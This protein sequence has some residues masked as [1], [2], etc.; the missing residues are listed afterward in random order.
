[1]AAARY[2]FP[3]ECDLLGAADPRVL[4]SLTYVC[5]TCSCNKRPDGFHFRCAE[6]FKSHIEGEHHSKALLR[7]Q[8]IEDPGVAQ[9]IHMYVNLE[10]GHRTARKQHQYEKVRN[11][12]QKARE[13]E[14]SLSPEDLKAHRQFKREAKKQ[15]LAAEEAANPEL[16]RQREEHQIAK[17]LHGNINAGSAP[18]KRKHSDVVADDC[19]PQASQQMSGSMIGVTTAPKPKDKC[20]I[21][22]GP[23]QCL[24][25][26]VQ[27]SSAGEVAEHL[28]SNGHKVNAMQYKGCALCGFKE[29][30]QENHVHAHLNSKAHQ[31]RLAKLQSMGILSF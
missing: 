14:K 30:L 5:H 28:G 3:P 4:A 12:V 31:K 26:A 25:C 23:W 2:T 9:K 22:G 11:L 27:C 13:F 16:K 18:K 15:A 21:Q 17:Q 7:A 8:T 29:P 19:A 10:S 20:S 1:M 24:V 6:N